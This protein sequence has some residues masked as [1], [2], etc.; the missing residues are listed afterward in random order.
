MGLGSLR[1]RRAAPEMMGK[2]G[3]SKF[4]VNMLDPV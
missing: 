4:L 2:E 3:S 1:D